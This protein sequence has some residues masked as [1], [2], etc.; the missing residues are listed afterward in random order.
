MKTR[1]RSFL[2]LPLLFLAIGLA[3]TPRVLAQP[4]W[5]SDFPNVTLKTQDGQE[6]RFYDDL[7]KGKTVVVNFMYTTCDGICERGTA[8]LLQLQKTLGDRLGKDVFIYSIT[9]TPEIDTPEVLAHYREAHGVKPGWT[10]LTGSLQDI[11]LLRNK[12]GLSNLTPALRQSLGLKET[13]AA[14]DDRTQHM[15][16]IAIIHEPQNKRAKASV[17]ARPDRILQIIEGMKPA[18]TSTVPVAIAAIRSVQAESASR[19]IAI[20]ARS[21]RTW[22]PSDVT[23]AP[24]D[25]IEWKICAGRHGVRITNWADVKDHVEVQAVAGQ[26]PFNA[27]T[28]QN[29]AS[30]ETAGQ[31]LLRLTIRSVP[32][33]TP[34]IKFD[35]IVH[36]AAMSGKVT[37]SAGPS[38][39][40][41]PA[42]KTI[43][44]T[45]ELKWTP[46]ETSAAVGDTIEWKIQSGFHGLKISNW[47][48][49]K[50]HVEVQ[51]VAGQQ[52]F[53]VA[54]GQTASP[55]STPGQ[56]L[57]RVKL[58]SAPAAVPAITFECTVHGPEMG[59]RVN[60]TAGG[61]VTKT[62]EGMANLTWSSADLT[63][64]VGD[65]LEW[66]INAG[67]HGLRISNWDEV[68]G[69]V[70]VE[71]VAG[72]QEFDVATGQNT[73]AT[74]VAG[75]VLLRLKIKSIPAGD[76]HIAFNCIIHSAME[77]EVTLAGAAAATVKTIE[78]LGTNAWNPASST[79]AVGDTLE[80]KIKA[81]F[82]GL[83]ITNWANVKNHVEVETV[84]GQQAFNPVTGQND[85]PT[86]TA[87]AV[88]L[89][90]KVKSM[91]A[92]GIKFDCIVHGTSMSGQ[93][94]IV[95]TALS[96]ARATAAPRVIEGMPDFTWNPADST[97]AV[98]DTLEWK[99]NAGFHGLRISNWAAV[100]DHVEIETVAGQ[101][102][103]NPVSGQNNAPTS[104]AGKLLL[105]LRIKSVP[106][107]GQIVFNCIV[108]AGMKGQVNVIATAPAL[109]KAK[110]LPRQIEGL[111]NNAWNPVNSTA[112][113]GD[114]VEWKIN[115][116]F[117]GLRI[118][119]WA[120]VKD[121]VE[122]ETTGFN[123][124]TGQNDAPSGV[125]GKILLRLRI[126]SVPA[127]TGEIQF[128][129]I[130]HG[131]RMSGKLVV[132]GT[133]ER[134]A[135]AIAPEDS[136]LVDRSG[137]T[138]SLGEFAG[139][140]HLLVLIKGAFCKHCM[141]QL[142]EFQK[143]IDPAKI[144]VVVI[145]PENDLADLE[146]VPFL[147]LADTELSV[148]RKMNALGR[149][150]MHGTFLVDADNQ[151]LLNE[152]GEEPFTDF[153]AIEKALARIATS[154]SP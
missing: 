64:A 103:F 89:R 47:V 26:Q 108:H 146:G 9:L 109:R 63:A 101:E 76:G 45:D 97:A 74:A 124:A 27:T 154:G 137:E 118:T 46:E 73:S 61:P 84:A 152:I 130:V 3:S 82:H 121:H 96:L 68:K 30:S 59:G 88:L 29:D 1:Y 143:R 48:D 99:I 136:I 145:T 102:P 115:A 35:C 40:P 54:T 20:E 66:R 42:A 38:P 107:G 150:P 134:S 126:K 139:R 23:A 16:M 119:N 127:G 51:P 78:G 41:T 122:V 114:T 128:N 21:D 81:G 90:L 123:T 100:K 58:K 83:R 62:I 72:Q 19:T 93:V 120:D 37:V 50:D 116:G 36:G 125:A 34:E 25:V 13:G 135:A 60:F 5:V 49:V 86:G 140:P 91:P 85:N 33:A 53:D 104:T 148:F 44:G 106:P 112:A 11:E 111:G 129:C 39:T 79:A 4:E 87:G 142:A 80:W 113:V 70:D 8:N 32:T 94:A 6:V 55:T 138:H 56:V 98:G 131:T 31:V 110:A 149:E 14:A 71:T 133:A 153:V 69:H 132:S 43:E 52:P 147:V 67:F 92:D 2:L 95:A 15:G 18:V 105:R 28:G 144:P 22:R 7:V 151:L 65:T 141:N 117:H 57:L 10:F 24:G 75:Q 17:L 12:L 77:G